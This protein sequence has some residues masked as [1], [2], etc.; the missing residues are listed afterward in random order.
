MPSR[1]PPTSQLPPSNRVRVSPQHSV[2]LNEHY[3]SLMS[4]A[5]AED[6][7][8]RTLAT[9]RAG[10]T[11]LMVAELV[12]AGQRT[13]A[14]HEL[15]RRYPLHFRKT[16]GPTRLGATAAREFS[17]QHRGCSLLGCPT[18]IGHDERRFRS[19]FVPGLSLDRLSSLGTEPDVSN[20]ALARELAPSAAV[21]LWHLAELALGQLDRL[22]S[23]GMAHGDAHLHNLI[24][25]PSPLSVVPVDFERAT[26]RSEVEPA[27]WREICQADRRP[28][29][30]FGVFLQCALGQQTEGSLAQ[31][32]EVL[33]DLVSS[34]GSFRAAIYERTHAASG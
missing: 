19:C 27:R 17:L 30:R 20:I 7:V 26:L 21:G 24:Y 23:G 13:R 10:A 25:C 5:P 3:L 32:I 6:F 18:P 8:V 9:R 34:P 22:H 12:I 1:Q 2:L 28:L 33:S 15:A 16:Y 14:A 31:G 29:L 11:P 4:S